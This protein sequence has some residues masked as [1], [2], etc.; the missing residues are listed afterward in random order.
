[1]DEVLKKLLNGVEKAAKFSSVDTS[2]IHS[3]DNAR[4]LLHKN[5]IISK[6]AIKGLKIIAKETR[7]GLKAKIIVRDNV[8]LEKP[9][10]LCFGVLEREGT[11]IIDM[12]LIV[13]KN[14]RI[15]AYAFCTFPRSRRVVH[16]MK[17]KFTLKENA[18]LDYHEFHYH[19]NK[20]ALVTPK[21]KIISK[22][23][24]VFNTS[25][26]L[27][28]GVVGKLEYYIDNQLDDDAKF[29][30]IARIR[31]RKKDR[32]RVMENAVLKGKSSSAIIKSRL[33]VSEQAK[34]KFMGEIIGV[35]D[36]SKGHVDCKEIIMDN[37][38]AE[39]IPKLKALNKKSR[40][41]HEAAIGSV[42]KKELQTL[43]A[44]GLSKE[45]AINL[46]VKGM[47]E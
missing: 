31:G 29:S 21:M 46:I 38:V 44:R 10:Y 16:K 11:Q 24:S 14:S 8:E 36:N 6:K 40:I 41:T 45:E 9:V 28:Y 34:A 25:I 42:D 30:A 27:L 20:G 47:L 4:L 26:T 17:A 15:K 23:K 35:G 32:I 33:V 7:N 18:K 39:T 2:K 22:R 3:N 5:K 1:M 19:G 12:E 43:Q 37:G 13:G